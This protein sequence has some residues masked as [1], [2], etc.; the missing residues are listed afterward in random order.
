MPLRVT[1]HQIET[2]SCSRRDA[3]LLGGG[4]TPPSVMPINSP[5]EPASGGKE[6]SSGGPLPRGLLGPAMWRVTTQGHTQAHCS[7]KLHLLACLPFLPYFTHSAIRAWTR[8]GCDPLPRSPGEKGPCHTTQGPR[9]LPSV[10]TETA[11]RGHSSF[12]CTVN[13]PLG[14]RSAD[15]HSTAVCCGNLLH[16]S[17]QPHIAGL[18]C[19]SPDGVLATATKICARRHSS[20]G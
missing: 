1:R 12:G 7:R 4:L 17:P 5:R 2:I 3:A 16:S 20:Q 9:F 19:S 10:T 14:S 6:N 8:W 18:F 13:L 11:P 15:P